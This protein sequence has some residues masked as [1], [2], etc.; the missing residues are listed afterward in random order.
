MGEILQMPN[1]NAR[2]KICRDTAA[3]FKA[4]N[5]TL[6]EGEWA[7]ET[8]TRNLKIGDGSTAYNN[9]SYT[10]I[11]DKWQKPSDWI[12]IRFGAQ[13]NS[14]YALVG[15]KADF[16]K[17]NIFP[18]KASVNNSGTYDIYI[19]GVKK[20]SAVASDTATT[21]NW[22]T[23]NLAS[24]FDVNYP[25]ALKTHIIRLTPT[26]STNHLD[27]PN[28]MSSDVSTTDG[29]GLLWLHFTTD[30]FM[31]MPNM[32]YAAGPR[33]SKILEAVTCKTDTLKCAWTSQT[34]F[35]AVSLKTIPV[36]ECMNANTDYNNAFYHA[37][38]KRLEFKNTVQLSSNRGQTQVDLPECEEIAIT[39]TYP[40]HAG[41][42]SN[43]PKLKRIVGPWDHTFGENYNNVFGGNA[44]ME[45][46]FLDFS[47]GS[48]VKIMN[49]GGTSSVPLPWFKGLL[50][51]ASAPFDN[52]TSP[53]ISVAYTGMTRGALVTLFNSMPYNVGY[54]IT[55][56]I[57]V[58]NGIATG[59]GTGNY[60]TIPTT[61]S[62]NYTVMEG[63]VTATAIQSG[64]I[65]DL[66]S[67]GAGYSNGLSFELNDTLWSIRFR[68]TKYSD[69]SAQYAYF[70]L[71]SKIQTDT[72]F[73]LNFAYNKT[74]REVSGTVTQG[75][76]TL[77][78]FSLSDVREPTN[79]NN[80]RIGLSFSSN[81]S[82]DLTYDLNN[83]DIKFDN[84]P[85]FTGKEAMTKTCSVVG[86]VGTA[87]LTA[88]DKAV[89]TNKG[90]ELTV[91]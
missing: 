91:E 13:D 80:C 52:T 67:I 11:E 82:P 74:T 8:D 15:H 85:W 18:I 6:L 23:L 3:N 59:F 53:Q 46:M 30:Y 55:G 58:T 26:V 62:P 35:R 38:I 70:D 68:Y 25:E 31:Y 12:D 32:C 75:G 63:R 42:F 9:L 84:V 17:Y 5:P 57:T 72:P 61:T 89:V 27:Y 81:Y 49:I 87:D 47:D 60:L 21:I 69:D 50:V 37:K 71:N 34:F 76:Q 64:H 56:N 66:I 79:Y 90:W 48:R 41:S 43:C 44:S 2:I 78:T 86:A 14:I 51:S 7:L 22:Q 88:E 19:D 39:G 33:N 73:V 45:D 20:Y 10:N 24:G 83:T 28:F 16:S 1:A 65:N 29:S 40:L 77:G 54:N 4:N 36:L